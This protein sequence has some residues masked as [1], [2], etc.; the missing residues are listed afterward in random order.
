MPTTREDQ[1]R[2]VWAR[3]EMYEASSPDGLVPADKFPGEL[4]VQAERMVDAGLL[5][6]MTTTGPAGSTRRYYRRPKPG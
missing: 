5:D 6:G 4:R 2:A 1:E 3:I